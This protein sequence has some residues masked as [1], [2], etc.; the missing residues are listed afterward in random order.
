[1]DLC[2]GSPSQ[3]LEVNALLRQKW[4]LW[5]NGSVKATDL[6]SDFQLREFLISTF[7]A[8]GIWEG[9]VRTVP[10]LPGSIWK[11]HFLSDEKMNTSAYAEWACRHWAWCWN[12][13]KEEWAR[14]ATWIP[15]TPLPV[16]CTPRKPLAYPLFNQAPP[17]RLLPTCSWSL[18]IRRQGS[19]RR[20]SSQPSWGVIPVV[21]VSE[22]IPLN[23]AT[24]YW[25]TGIC[26]N[27]CHGLGRIMVG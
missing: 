23:I 21:R 11:V 24:F 9:G 6:C 8:P 3:Q 15:N 13:R 1:M 4:C 25:R 2:K 17:T 5:L 20:I 26:N 10:N 12:T 22:C 16:L 18:A 27:V 14:R 19:G 7:S